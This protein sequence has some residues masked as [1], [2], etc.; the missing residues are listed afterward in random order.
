MPVPH[1]MVD[2]CRDEKEESVYITYKNVLTQDDKA[3]DLNGGNGKQWLVVYQ[4][5]SKEAGTAILAPEDNSGF[6]VKTGGGSAPDHKYSPLHL[7][8]TPETAQNL[9][10]ADGDKGWSYNDKNKGTYL[11]FTHADTNTADTEVKSEQAGSAFS[12]GIVIII[13]AIGVVTGMFICFVL[14]LP[15][16][17]KRNLT[18]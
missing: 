11:F 13:G 9:T 2:I 16:R 8:G 18:D 3:A 1:H 14:M 10:Y 6:V 7:F 5:R 17:K 15:R 12:T 4:T